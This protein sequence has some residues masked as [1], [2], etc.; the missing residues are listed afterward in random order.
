MF[1]KAMN[2][3]E[4]LFHWNAHPHQYITL[5][6][7][8]DKMI[9]FEKGDL[10]FIFNF[11]HTKSYEHYKIGTHWSSEHIIIMDSDAKEFGGHNR[12]EPAN[13]KTF[14]PVTKG[15][16]QGRN[17]SFQIYIPNRTAIILCAEENLVSTT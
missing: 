16:W 10:L 12:L 7:E 15:T 17:N 5:Q 8:G 11:H 13:K 14:F 1:D 3:L 9:V 4:E 6:H 2:E